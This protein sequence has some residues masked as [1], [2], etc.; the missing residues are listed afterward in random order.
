MTPASSNK[1]R[2]AVP[3]ALY[4]LANTVSSM[5]VISLYFSQWVTVDKGREDLWYSVFYGGSMLAVALTLPYLGLWS[6]RGNRRPAFLGVFTAV[7]VAATAALSWFTRMPG[8][9]G[10][11]LALV[12]FALSNYAFQ[13]GLVFYNALLP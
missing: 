5:T 4:A 13:G 3:C 7:S 11:L 10:F 8:T 9:A 1:P 12:V 6:D 2:G